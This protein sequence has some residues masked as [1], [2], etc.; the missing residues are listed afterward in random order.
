MDV[1]L[2]GTGTAM[3]SPDRVQSGT[4]VRTAGRT[5]LVDC[6]S[7]VV[8]RLACAGVDHRAVDAVLVTHHHLDHV[9]DL[10]TLA[11]ARWL[12]GQES[13]EVV[14][15]PGIAE[16]CRHL[17]AVDRLGERVDLTVTERTLADAPFAVGGV[18]VDAAGTTHSKP[19]FAYRFGD[20]L[21]LSGDT[22]PAP[23][24]FDLADGV[25]TLV[26]ECSYPDSAGTEGH[27]TPTELGRR[28]AEIA[29]ERVYLT[30]LFPEAERATE[31]IR[32]TVARATDAEVSIATD[33]AAFEI[34]EAGGS[35][36]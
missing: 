30:H 35:V 9:A 23:D 1:T 11:K 15:P 17:L 25:D 7:G 21:A 26:H 4:L 32:R 12:D 22:E 36:S 31:E 28:L 16:V 24:V 13:L 19:G 20:A 6:G 5:V 3:P 33:L 29:V 27:T 10:P 18:S 14:G 8:H 34:P 2:L